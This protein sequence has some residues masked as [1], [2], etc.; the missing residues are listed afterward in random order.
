MRSRSLSLL[1]VVV[2]SVT[3]SARAQGIQGSGAL[4]LRD[5]L[6]EA[7][8]A[9]PEL[10]VLQRQYEAAQAAIPEARFLEAPMFETQIWGWPVT[11][12]N[13]A[14]TDMYMFM[15]E[16]ALPGRGKRQAR[17]VV[18]T[19]DAELSRQQIA[20]R[21]SSILNEVK[22]A[23]AELLLARATLALYQQQTPLLEDAAEAATL[24]YAS[25]HSGQRDTVTSVVELSRLGTDS[26][27]WRERAR[28]AET[29]VNVLLGR[30]PDAPVTVVAGVDGDVPS[31][32]DAERMALERNPEVA[33]ASVEISREEAELARLRG[34]RRPDFVVGGG[35]M[36]QPGGAGAWTA[37]GAMTWPN[38]P[39]ARGRLTTSLE[40]QEKRVL[41]ARARRDAVMS[42]V[43]RE[44]H[45]AL[46]H[47]EAARDRAR[48]L[49]SSVIPHIEHVFEAARV[50]YVS[51]RG[52]FTDLLETQRVLLST[53]MEVASA[54]A[55][56]ARAV[57]D[58]EMALGAIPEDK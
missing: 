30:A 26:I 45:E 9:N 20:V 17:E 31:L 16:Q 56:L 51:D 52:E 6:R 2:L 1:A 11:A 25:G 10:I 29:R 22:Q 28:V 36:L 35:Y 43:R 53:R 49:E 54:R 58:L 46:V 5:A 7:I 12:I 55:D 42:G 47:V 48:L 41:A 13:P 24:R 3:T 57:G 32:V 50:A 37:R 23:Y 4:S 38:A 8:R 15:T 21:S 39:W 14:R 27:E 18:V 40:T 33:M 19:R 44:I 34:E